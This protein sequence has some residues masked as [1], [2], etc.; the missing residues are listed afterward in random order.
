MDIPGVG[1]AGR[2]SAALAGESVLGAAARPQRLLFC[3]GPVCP[4][5]RTRGPL[6]REQARGAAVQPGPDGARRQPWSHSRQGPCRALGLLACARPLRTGH[7]TANVVSC[8]YPKH[9]THSDIQQHSCPIADLTSSK[10]CCSFWTSATV[11][12]IA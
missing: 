4:G 3:S 6:S 12:P 1:A 10:I 8:C 5:A 2:L 9:K 7:V 11:S